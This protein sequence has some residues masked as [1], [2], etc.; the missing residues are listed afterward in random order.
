MKQQL[1]ERELRDL[2]AYLQKLEDAVIQEDRSTAM[3]LIRENRKR[4]AVV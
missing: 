1:L 4:K 3:L 2:R